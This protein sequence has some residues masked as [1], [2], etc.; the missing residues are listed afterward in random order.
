[1]RL[2]V[3]LDLASRG[4]H[5]QGTDQVQA[6]IVFQTGAQGGRL[7]TRSPSPL[8][9]RDQRKARFIGKNES[10]AQFTAV[11]LYAARYTASNGQWLFH[12][13]PN[14]DAA[15]FENSSQ[16]GATGTKRCSND[17]VRGTTARSA[18]QSDPAS[19]NLRHSPTHTLRVPKRPPTGAVV[20]PINDWGVPAGVRAACAWG[21]ETRDATGTRS[22][23]SRQPISQPAWDLVHAVTGIRHADDAWLIGSMFQMV[24]WAHY[25]TETTNVNINY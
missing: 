23:E 7:P 19:S 11:F 3:Q 5:T 14:R 22:G 12:L 1:M 13:A 16:D 17:S 21:A 4:R 2:Q 10:C 18:E 15:V 25:S 9:R 20:R 8:Q 6:L 24:A